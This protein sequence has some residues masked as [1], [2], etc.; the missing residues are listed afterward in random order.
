[1][2]T[3]VRFPNGDLIL[4][5]LARSGIRISK[6]KW[7]GLWPAEVLANIPAERLARLHSAQ[8]ERGWLRLAG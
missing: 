3:R 6:M 7:G 2:W 8:D 5:G 1:M 4:I